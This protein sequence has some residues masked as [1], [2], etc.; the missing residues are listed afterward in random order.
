ME[1]RQDCEATRKPRLCAN[2]WAA[3]AGIASSST[4]QS[5]SPGQELTAVA[6]ALLVDT[7]SNAR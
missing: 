6:Q 1:A 5:E 3:R 7:M 4:A 2:Q